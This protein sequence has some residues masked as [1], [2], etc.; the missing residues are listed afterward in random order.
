MAVEDPESIDE[1]SHMP[2]T[3]LNDDQERIAGVVLIVEV[4]TNVE[5]FGDP[6]A[7]EETVLRF[8]LIILPL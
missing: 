1:C 2:S 8:N 4:G 5:V 3:F 7:I 6:Q